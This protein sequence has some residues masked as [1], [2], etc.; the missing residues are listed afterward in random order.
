MA[1]QINGVA[2]PAA[3]LTRGKYSAPRPRTV[4]RNGAGAAVIVGLTPVEWRWEYMTASEFGYFW[5]TLGVGAGGIV[6][7][8]NNRLWNALGAETAYSA[9]A[10]QMDW[11]QF[12]GDLYRGVTVTI[13]ELTP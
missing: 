8:T 4:R 7:V 13:D 6:A 5:T 2:V 9:G 11:D 3:L 12:T 10:V 1:I